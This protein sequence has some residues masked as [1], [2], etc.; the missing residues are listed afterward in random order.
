MEQIANP[1]FN[2]QLA[3]I[4]AQA[5]HPYFSL[6]IFAFQ[7]FSLYLF[8]YYTS[9]QS[10]IAEDKKKIVDLETEARVKQRDQQL[11]DMEA[12]WQLKIERLEAKTE[13]LNISQSHS[14][15]ELSAQVTA[16]KNMMERIFAK[17]DKIDDHINSKKGEL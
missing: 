10:S 11:K 3:G 17:L 5:G 16:I 9:K 13:Q 1:A 7:A 14:I 6:A 15:E 12:A 2:D 8:K 4:L